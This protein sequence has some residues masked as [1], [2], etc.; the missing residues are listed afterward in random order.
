MKNIIK[1]TF[2]V[3]LL[4]FTAFPQIKNVKTELPERFKHLRSIEP[5]LCYCQP[6]KG[7]GDPELSLMFPYQIKHG[8]IGRYVAFLS[9][10][11]HNRLIQVIVI[12]IMIMLQVKKS[13][14]L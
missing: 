11:P 4:S 10:L 3:V 12:I 13:V 2:F 1:E 6:G 7:I 5:E 14:A 9:H 8:I